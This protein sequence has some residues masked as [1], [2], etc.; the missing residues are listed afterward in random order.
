M[1]KM[2]LIVILGL[3]ALSCILPVAAAG[4]R[5]GNGRGAG[6][7][8]T[9]PE[10]PDINLTDNEVADLQFMREEEQMVHDLYVRWSEM[11]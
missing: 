2:I 3:F 10:P 9:L 4:R 11:Y 8:V 6:M 1:N 5:F 7:N